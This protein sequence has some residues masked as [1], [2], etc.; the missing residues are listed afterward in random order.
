MTRHSCRFVRTITFA[1]F[2]LPF[3]IFLPLSGTAFADVLARAAGEEAAESIAPDRPRGEPLS[4]ERLERWRAMSPEERER[5]RER[6]RRW[7]ELDRKSTR[8]NSSH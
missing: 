5:L 4:P 6:Y 7:K 1:V 8:L 2:L 3:G